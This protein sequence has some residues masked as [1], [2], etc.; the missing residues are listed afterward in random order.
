MERLNFDRCLAGLAATTTNKSLKAAATELLES[1]G[2]TRGL[3]ASENPCGALGF[4]ATLAN[5]YGMW[6]LV[7]MAKGYMAGILKE[8]ASFQQRMAE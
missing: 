2:Y 6:M 3:Y 4:P 1:L 5:D 7:Y 8:N